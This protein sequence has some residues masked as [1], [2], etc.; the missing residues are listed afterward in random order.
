MPNKTHIALICFSLSLLLGTS[1]QIFSQVRSFQID[2]EQSHIQFK[3]S[4]L[5]AFKVK[6]HF[7]DYSGII[8]LNN[9]NLINIK[10]DILVESIN[11]DNEERD[12]IIVEEAYFNVNIF[13]NM[14]F[15][16]KEFKAGEEGLEMQGSLKIKNTQRTINFPYEIVISE[17]FKSVTI[18][19]ELQIK[20]KDF[21]LIFGSMNGLI[22]NKVD[23]K[24]QI[25]GIN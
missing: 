18:N 2:K 23:I 6:G 11:T 22:G 14:V 5:G 21:D 4:H 9:E 20:R 7:D 16:A 19:A 25:V 8:I 1:E 13:P 24:L 3:V 15:K 17:D 10:C 12:N